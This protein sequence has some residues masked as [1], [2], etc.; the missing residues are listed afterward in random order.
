MSKNCI[1]IV[2]F[3]LTILNFLPFQNSDI[4]KEELDNAQTSA[5]QSELDSPTANTAVIGSEGEE[6]SIQSESSNAQTDQASNSSDA[7]SEKE[8]SSTPSSPI[9]STKPSP[10]KGVHPLITRILLGATAPIRATQTPLRQVLQQRKS[11]FSPLQLWPIAH[12]S[13]RDAKEEDIFV[14]PQ[15]Y[16][17]FQKPPAT[18]MSLIER[19]RA[20]TSDE[21]HERYST[22]LERLMHG[23][24]IVGHI[25]GFLTSRAK[26][27]LKKLHKLF[28]TEER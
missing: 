19:Y 11:I 6:Q 18:R 28:A 22:I 24:K 23:V 21:R 2:F 9:N 27:S 15:P 10:A 20:M 16:E 26:S 14:K 7:N 5:T 3:L 1:F 17:S 13:K 25:D 4:P 8:P 12:R